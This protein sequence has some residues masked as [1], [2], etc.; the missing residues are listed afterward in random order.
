M[1]SFLISAIIVLFNKFTLPYLMHQISDHEEWKTLTELNISFATSL[2]IVRNM[3][4]VGYKYFDL[5]HHRDERNWNFL[6]F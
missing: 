4:I 2:S 1:I 3:L 5:T 6:N